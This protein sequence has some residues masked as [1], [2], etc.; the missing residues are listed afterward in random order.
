ME[1]YLSGHPLDVTTNPVS[2]ASQLYREQR[3]DWSV[4]V[5]SEC[6]V[7]EH[8]SSITVVV[9]PVLLIATKISYRVNPLE[10]LEICLVLYEQRDYEST[11]LCNSY[12]ELG[13]SLCILLCI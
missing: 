11:S 10:I 1:Y 12:S 2:Y 3:D 8:S 6:N 9:N 7:L 5:L 13:S 4:S